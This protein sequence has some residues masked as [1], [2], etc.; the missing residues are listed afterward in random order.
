[1]TTFAEASKIATSTAIADIIAYAKKENNRV[2]TTQP[3]P[4][5][6]VRWVDGVQDAPEEYFKRVIIYEYNRYDLVANSILQTLRQKSPVKSGDYVRGHTLFI[7]GQE[8]QDLTSW[9]DGDEISIANYAPYARKLEVGTHNGKKLKLSV[10]PHIY[11][12]TAQLARRQ[13]KD[14][15][16]ISFTFRGIVS[17]AQ[18][19]PLLAAPTVLSR[20]IVR[21][22]NGQFTKGTKTVAVSGG[23]HN[24]SS[25]RYPTITIN[26]PGSFASRAG[27]K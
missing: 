6:F 16:D 11:E 18:V 15:A 12:T 24:K 23:S 1:M 22:S 26:P 14:V 9:T 25:M 10:S 27:I 8:V 2:L 17:G 13:Y 21:G 7:N 4:L 5:K 3:L 19:N 20:T